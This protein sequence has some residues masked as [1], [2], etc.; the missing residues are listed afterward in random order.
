M[1]VATSIPQ[2]SLDPIER[3]VPL[4]LKLLAI[5]L[6]TVLLYQSASSASIFPPGKMSMPYYFY[7]VWIITPLHEGGHFLFMLFGRTMYILEG[8]F[9]QVMIPLILF[10]VAL[11]Q[12][13]FF[14][15]IWLML[16]GIHMIALSPYIFDAPFRSLPLLGGRKEGHD[17]YNLLIHYQ[18]LDWAEPLSNLAYYGG[19]LL[20]IG[21]VIGGIST[22]LFLFFR[23]TPS[24]AHAQRPNPSTK[25]KTAMKELKQ[26]S[27]LSELDDTF[28]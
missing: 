6:V 27:G 23:P 28:S 18:A 24:P 22:S 16:A 13:S 5:L 11:R 19:I 7:Y 4:A 25:T 21:G 26:E 20:G 2:E 1:K 15:A 12:R 14:A 9:W 8:S 17:W 10:G 3:I